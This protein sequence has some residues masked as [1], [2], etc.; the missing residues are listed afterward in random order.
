[1][2]GNQQH[3]PYRAA[4]T[5]SRFVSAARG[6]GQLCM[7]VSQSTRIGFARGWR[8]GRIEVN[9]YMTCYNALASFAT[10]LIWRKVIKHV[11]RALE[12][13]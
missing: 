11:S 12:L 7:K 9:D 10:W 5:L 4:E 13:A 8:E 2:K 1:M 3:K 6:C